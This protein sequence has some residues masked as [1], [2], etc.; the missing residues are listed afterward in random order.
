MNVTMIVARRLMQFIKVEL[1]LCGLRWRFSMCV[2]Q[3]EYISG[4][5]CVL[6]DSIRLEYSMIPLS[7][8][9]VL[10]Y[11][12]EYFF[13]YLTFGIFFGCFTSRIF[14]W[15]YLLFISKDSIFFLFQFYNVLQIG[16]FFFIL[17]CFLKLI[18][19]RIYLSRY[20]QNIF[21]VSFM[22]SILFFHS[23][24]V[25]FLLLYNEQSKQNILELSTFRTRPL[26][27][28]LAIPLKFK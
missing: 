28:F 1:I 11:P 5:F 20:V 15:L 13:E 4:I 12:T 17:L 6:D 27:R 25:L 14:Y 2:C 9:P 26:K 16:I 7:N 23:I 3:G 8:A 24:F 22:N 19:S 18:S 10:Q 21:C